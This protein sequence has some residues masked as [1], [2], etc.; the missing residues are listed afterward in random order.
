MALTKHQ[1]LARGLKSLLNALDDHHQKTAKMLNVLQFHFYETHLIYGR[2]VITER[3]FETMMHTHR[4]GLNLFSPSEELRSAARS[5]PLIGCNIALRFYDSSKVR[6]NP[7][8][9]PQDNKWIT[10]WGVKIVLPSESLQKLNESMMEALLYCASASEMS[11]WIDWFER[12]DIAGTLTNQLIAISTSVHESSV[13]EK[14]LNQPAFTLF[15]EAAFKYHNQKIPP[16]NVFNTKFAPDEESTIAQAYELLLKSLQ[17]QQERD[18]DDFQHSWR[19]QLEKLIFANLNVTQEQKRTI[20]EERFSSKSRNSKKDPSPRWKT[21]LVLDRQT[22]GS[23]IRHFAERFLKNPQ[24]HPADG[25]IVLLLWVMIYIAQ[26]P[27]HTFSIKSLLELTTADVEDQIIR[28]DGHEIDI[29]GGLA[30]LLKEFTG[31]VKSERQQKLFPNLNPD[32]LEDYFHRASS[33]LL[34]PGSL[35]ALPEAF[36]TFPHANKHFRMLAQMRQHQQKHPTQ[37]HHNLIS[38]NEL[39][40]QLIEKSKP[41]KA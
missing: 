38:R 5:A 28:I 35:P 26:D 22:Y 31:G 23:F 32:K 34:P 1:K 21:S 37:V 8:D 41:K 27:D 33:A 7:P 12:E 2:P 3:A 9:A 24:K 20:L 10:P 39:K 13:L 11:E 6:V 30:S 15:H 17:S 36:L 29:S 16:S 25:E 19:G 4:C 40:R 18:F 14:N